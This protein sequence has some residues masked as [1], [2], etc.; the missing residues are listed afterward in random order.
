MRIKI[1]S[2][3]LS[4]AML[5]L[6]QGA[7]AHPG[8]EE[9]GGFMAGFMHPLFGVDHLLAML[10]V[11]LWAAR[12][13][14]RAV[15]ALP[16]TFMTAMGAGAALAFAGVGVPFVEPFVAASVLVLG[17]VL[18]SGRAVQASAP[19]C[20]VAA[21]AIFHGVAHGAEI[22]A[23]AGRLVYLAGFIVA[24][25]LIHIAGIGIARLLNGTKQSSLLQ[26][27]A[28][29]PIALAGAWMLAGAM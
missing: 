24:T 23:H 19:F 8:H 5:V 11:G 3:I 10:A 17:L 26:R 9:A 1:G 12:L 14:G 21:F 15:W 16:L 20:V 27:L 6:A 4:I 29:A 18:V 2:G 7:W 22:P 28:A 25:G 13:G